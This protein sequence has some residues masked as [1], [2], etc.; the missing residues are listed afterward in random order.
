[1]EDIISILSRKKGWKITFHEVYDQ[2]N[3]KRCSAC[4]GPLEGTPTYYIEPIN[5][6]A[7]GLH[8]ACTEL[9]GKIEQH[10]LHPQHILTVS[11][12]FTYF[13]CDGCG[14]V[15]KSM[16]YRCKD[17]KLKLDFHCVSK[18]DGKVWKKRV[19][20]YSLYHRHKLQLFYGDGAQLFDDK[21]CPCCLKDYRSPSYACTTCIRNY[22]SVFFIHKFCLESIP[23]RVQSSFHP[24]H[25]LS[26]ARIPAYCLCS[27]C[28][29]PIK[30][31]ALTCGECN[32]DFHVSCGSRTRPG[33]R[34]N[35]LHPHDMHYV[36]SQSR[37]FS[38]CI[39]CRMGCD[40]DYYYKCIECDAY[41]HLDC[42]PIPEIVEHESHDHPLKLTNSIVTDRD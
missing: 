35:H 17:C 40:V 31:F 28:G 24:Q 27:A 18:I 21:C 15:S 39:V 38:R 30:T 9:P 34:L 42:S 3:W 23:Q 19:K 7:Y 20:I 33:L 25:P 32:L 37:S 16:R 22:D 10:P 14:Y 5:G 2:F 6:Q 8:K 12:Q 11:N 1:M 13:I 4:N 36:L 29:F 41:M 26:I